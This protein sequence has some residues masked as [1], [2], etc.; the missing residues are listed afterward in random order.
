MNNTIKYKQTYIFLNKKKIIFN[1]KLNI[2]LI[3]FDETS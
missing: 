1:I 2:T 3:K